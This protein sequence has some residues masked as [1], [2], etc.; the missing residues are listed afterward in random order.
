M[1]ASLPWWGYFAAGL[2]FGSTLTFLWHVLSQNRL[3]K[4]IQTL[5]SERK[6]AEKERLFL[7]ESLKKMESTFQAL[8]SRTLQSNSDELVK[9]ASE[10][11]QAIVQPLQTNLL[12]LGNYVHELEQK[13]EGAYSGLKEQIRALN[14]AY[15]HLQSSTQEL[16]QALK[17]T[18]SRGQWGELQLRRVVELAGM[19]EHVDFNVQVSG[20]GVRPDLL[21]HLPNGG[22]LPVDAK[23]PFDAYLKATATRDDEE[24]STYLQAHARA[25]KEHIRQLSSKAY[26]QAFDP[27]P[28]FVVLFVPNEAMLSAALQHDP[29]LLDYAIRQQV[30]LTSPIT[31]L[32]LLRT[33][34]WGW[35]QNALAENA[36]AI[37][38]QGN[39]LYSRL[40]T[41]TGHLA[42]LQKHLGNAIESYN[43][44][45]GSL[46]SRV[47]P[48]VRRLREMGIGESDF[49]LPEK[50]D[51]R[52]RSL[53]NPFDEQH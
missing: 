21:I 26:W 37:A 18:R 30:M 45:I 4:R 15:Q 9:R 3:Q 8:A 5:E 46:E 27:A 34:G 1:T 14:E 29:D 2:I 32:A 12:Q 43:Q 28:E 47:A 17:S 44:A 41:F 48:A 16:T 50:V 36:K 35:T 52:P 39:E 20:N 53:Q 40:Q 10:Q 24:A 11:M 31:L 13:R 25:L 51:T 33:I 22:H 38:Q 19:L 23:T 42:N 7:E 49:S 6:L